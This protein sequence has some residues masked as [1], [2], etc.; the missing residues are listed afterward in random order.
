MK[1]IDNVSWQ[2]MQ[3]YLGERK[4]SK[5]W[6]NWLVRK[7]VN[8]NVVKQDCLQSAGVLEKKA[9]IIKNWNI[10]RSRYVTEMWKRFKGLIWEFVTDCQC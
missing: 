2:D 7:Y 6:K 10:F 4:V 5:D 9:A 1:F 8:A 3:T